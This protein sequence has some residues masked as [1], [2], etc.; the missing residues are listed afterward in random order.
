MISA[1]AP[2]HPADTYNG[3]LGL[4]TDCTACPADTKFPVDGSP[5]AWTS[6]AAAQQCDVARVDLEC[7]GGEWPGLS[8]CK[9]HSCSVAA[10]PQ[11]MMMPMFAA[12]T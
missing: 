4:S 11:L 12:C 9:P 5:D 1:S 7:R 6:Y 8:L 10:C 3:I 2:G